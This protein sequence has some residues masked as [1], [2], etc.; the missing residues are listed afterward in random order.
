MSFNVALF[1]PFL[2]IAE[3]VQFGR[4]L[5]PLDDLEHRHEIDVV[6]TDHF[7]DEF[8]Q[9]FPEFLFALQPG[10]VEV[11]AERRAV[12]VEMAV[13]IVAQQTAELFAGLDVG[14][15]VDHVATGEG[16]VE[17]RVVSPVQFVHDHFPDGVASARA[18]VGV[19]VAFVGHSEVEGV[20]PNW[21]AA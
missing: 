6:A 14:A 20:G 18:I 3:S 4:V 16:F 17:G 12:A 8:N 13:E 5:H 7:F 2:E 9:F 21:H 19:S 10:R 11:E 15:G 1:F